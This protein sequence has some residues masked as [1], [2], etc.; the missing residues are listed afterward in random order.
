MKRINIQSLGLFLLLIVSSFL[1][2]QCEK[3]QEE[4]RKAFEVN[5][6]GHSN[7][8]NSALREKIYDMPYE[9]LTVEESQG[10]AFMRE[11]EKLAHDV[12][13]F[14]YNI[15]GQS[16]FS[17]IA[18]SEQTHTEAVAVL[19]DKYDLVDP[20]E[21]K[22]SGEFLNGELQQLY[23]ELIVLGADNLT[24]A[25]KVGGA[26]EEIDILDLIGQLDNVV[27]NED[28]IFVYNN[29]LTGS[30]NHLRAFVKNMKNQGIDYEPQYLDEDLYQSIIDG[31]M[32]H[33]FDG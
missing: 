30:R 3:E 14:L 32:E 24:E 29:L 12:Y 5:E 27:D 17:N 21:D 19:I 22:G 18:N 10:I 6:Q 4:K 16:I 26:I 9:D 28:I 20:N 7:F 11:E 33:G 8:N 15:H 13:I 31:E 23:N 25:L 2:I 1:M